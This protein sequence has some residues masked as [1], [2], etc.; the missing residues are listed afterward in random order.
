MPL[1]ILP[2]FEWVLYVHSIRMETSNLPSFSLLPVKVGAAGDVQIILLAIDDCVICPGNE[3][4]TF[5]PLMDAHNG[6]LTDVSGMY[7]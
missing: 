1:E 5:A 4:M 6:V 3:Y 7:G 2:N